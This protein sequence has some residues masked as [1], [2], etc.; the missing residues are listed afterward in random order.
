MNFANKLR[1]ILTLATGLL[2]FLLGAPLPL[3]AQATATVRGA[4]KDASG[5]PVEGAFV[6]IR[7]VDSGIVFMV[8]SQAQGRYSSPNLLPGKYMIEGVGGEYQSDPAGPVEAGNG[9][10]AQMDVV[11]SVARKAA[12]PRQR[13]TDSDF[14]GVMPEGPAIRAGSVSVSLGS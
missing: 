12:P 3:K 6:R 10:P 14:A 1:G 5:K 4:V 9:Q 13:L 7:N 8:V 2:L 11:L